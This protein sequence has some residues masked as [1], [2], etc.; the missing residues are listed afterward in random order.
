MNKVGFIWLVL[1]FGLSCPAFAKA[2]VANDEIEFVMAVIGFLL[3]L[4]GMT[5]AI[6]YLIKNGR[7][8]FIRFRDFTKDKTSISRDQA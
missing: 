8:L 2:G 3:L 4:A 5:A 6:E 7:G 1:F